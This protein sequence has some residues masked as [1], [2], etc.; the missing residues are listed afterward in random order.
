MTDVTR[1]LVVLIAAA[2][3]GAALVPAA[4][5]GDGSPP[6]LNEAYP[7]PPGGVYT[8]Q[9]RGFGHGHGLSQWGAYGAAKVADLSSNQILHFYYPHTTLATEPVTQ[10][11]R[12]LLT[13]AAAPAHRYLEVEPADGLTLTPQAGD[14][15]V[16]PTQTD[17]GD[18]ID[19]WRLRKTAGTVSLQA[20]SVKGW[21]VMTPDVG[22]SA[23]LSDPDALIGVVE[24]NGAAT[25]TVR[26]RGTLAAQLQSGSFQVVDDV[27]VE[28][29]LRSVVPAEMP[30][31]WTP[32]ALQAQAVAARTYTW[33]AIAS[34]KA[35]WYDIDGDT[36]D[37]AY[38]G[39]GAETP[40]TD[41]AIHDTAGE[42]IVDGTGAAIF[43]QYFSADGGW[44]VSGG[45]P[46]LPAKH[47]PYD[48]E[49]PN[50]SHLWS[51]TVSADAIASA[52]P[53]VGTVQQLVITGRDGH[54]AWGG[55][56]T[57]LSVV[58]SA[59][60]K[61][62]TGSA[63]A[64]AFGLRSEWF[65]P[66]PAPGPPTAV[67]ATAKAHTVTVTWKAPTPIAGAAAVT[68]YRIALA[69]GRHVVSGDATTLTASFSKI[70]TGDYTASVAAKSAAGRGP[71]A[72]DAV[73]VKPL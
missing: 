7:V 54:G 36:R 65:R 58:G 27:L 2:T 70:A 64:A 53:S 63:F 33:H 46:Y 21:S 57:A 69:P 50:S 42:V 4:A 6:A 38:G 15:T 32:A 31:T 73:R 59:G 29:Y 43:A 37:Q 9:G 61:T 41:A 44:T 28:S 66:T 49:V 12:V 11:V 62:L 34:P 40:K 23:T 48:G 13:A 3:V 1:R 51:T 5:R 22:T 68:G 35:S 18:A 30:S 72:S 39:F 16:L 45:Q 71:A 55:R 17:A 56:V 25:K 60:T 26:Y 8:I 24:P 14:A 10:Q 52:Y 19:L 47:D 67:A 20:H